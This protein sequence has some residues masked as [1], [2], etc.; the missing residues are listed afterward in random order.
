MITAGFASSVPFMGKTEIPPFRQGNTYCMNQLA[1]N[2]TVILRPGGGSVPRLK[3]PTAL[4][5]NRF[6]FLL[7][8]IMARIHYG[9]Y[10]PH[11]MPWSHSA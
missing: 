10:K 2:P 3:I 5:D 9:P 6:G 11:G 4:F 7:I 8:P 1:L